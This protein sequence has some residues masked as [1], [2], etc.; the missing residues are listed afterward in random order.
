MTGASGVA[1]L[2][3]GN[4]VLGVG[5]PLVVARFASIDLSIEEGALVSLLAV[6]VLTLAEVLYKVEQMRSAHMGEQAVWDRRH[7]VDDALSRL[8]G[9]LHQLVLDEDLRESF[10]LDHYQRDLEL[11]LSRVQTSLNT[12]E[13]QI[14]RNHI[15]S[16]AV[17]LSIYDNKEH[18]L[19]LATHC[20]SDVTDTFDPTFRVYFH[21]WLDRLKSRKVREFRRL[22]VLDDIAQLDHPNSRKL[23]AFHNGSTRGLSAKIVNRAELHRFKADYQ[24][25][26]GVDD[27]GV[28]SSEYIYLG[29]TRQDENISGSF[30]RDRSLIDKY[31]NMYEALWDSQFAQE[32]GSVVAE[33]VT[34]DQLFDPLYAIP[35]VI[36]GDPAATKD[37]SDAEEENG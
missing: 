36:E 32:V 24:L 28:F 6:L 21:A 35:N 27:F 9:G 20:L 8:R 13:I 2:L 11:L 17:L 12:K 31:T 22:F 34:I 15:D 4:V 33:S 26:D 7:S 25:N 16:T 14:D 30:S 1:I 23:V 3:S 10:Y 19:F 18:S 37:T 29:Q 5:V